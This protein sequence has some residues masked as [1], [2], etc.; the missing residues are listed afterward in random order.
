MGFAMPSR[1]VVALNAPRTK[2]PCAACDFC[3][4]YYLRGA[5]EAVGRNDGELVSAEG[6]E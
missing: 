5:V 6:C 3:E 4:K 1:G 2:C